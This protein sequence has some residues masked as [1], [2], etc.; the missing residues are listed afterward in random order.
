[1]SLEPKLLGVMAR[2]AASATYLAHTLAR[3]CLEK[4]CGL[5]SVDGVHRPATVESWV[6]SPN[7]VSPRLE[8]LN[9]GGKTR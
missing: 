1:M 6:V 4:V 9:K 5:L 2:T 7:K 3:V 8:L